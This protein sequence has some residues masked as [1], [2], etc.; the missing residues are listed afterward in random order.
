METFMEF[1][2]V[3]SPELATEATQHDDLYKPDAIKDGVDFELGSKHPAH[4]QI[5]LF[6]DLLDLPMEGGFGE[7][8]LEQSHWTTLDI[9]VV[10]NHL[11]I[12]PTVNTSVKEESLNTPIPLEESETPSI[13]TSINAF[14]QDL[15]LQQTELQDAPVASA[16]PTPSSPEA[17]VAPEIDFSLNAAPDLENVIDYGKGE[18]I[19]SPLSPEEIESLLSS[20][21]SSPSEDSSLDT[22]EASVICSPSDLIEIVSVKNQRASP[23]SKPQTVCKSQKSKG[24]KQTASISPNPSDLE[25]ELMS[26]K[27]RKKL[28]NKNAAIRYRMKKKLESDLK[29]EEEDDLLSTNE[30]LRE[31]VDQLTREIKY[32]KNLINEVRNARGLPS[33]TS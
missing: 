8:W 21:V 2:D 16:S 26:K 20:A 3:W 19:Q 22:D 18:F 23:Y 4:M 1:G 9:P 6:G 11:D 30:N 27:D 28:Q 15:L 33:I 24:R 10:E 25:L 14:L 17:Q 5:D 13:K 31:K 7:D 12:T 32:M 29:K